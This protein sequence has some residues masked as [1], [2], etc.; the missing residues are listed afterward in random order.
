MQQKV[1]DQWYSFQRDSPLPKEDTVFLMELLAVYLAI[2][3]FQHYRIFILLRI[4]NLSLLPLSLI[5]I[6]VLGSLGI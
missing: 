4:I 6:T 5:T 2:K 3:H 1:D